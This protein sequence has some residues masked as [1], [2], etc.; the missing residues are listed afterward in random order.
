MADNSREQD[1]SLRSI[2]DM[3]ARSE[4]AQV[5]FTPGTS[6]HTLQRNRIHALR[7]AAALI[8]REAAGGSGAM[9]YT[10]NDQEKARAPLTSLISKSE[11]ARQK[12]APGTWQHN[13]L[14]GNLAALHWAE[15]L[16]SKA[17]ET[18]T[19]E[20]NNGPE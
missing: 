4:N 13:M 12:I 18:G 9:A 1:E 10:K 16:L 8:R 7:V 19:E 17:L 11:K 3:I 6:Q 20:Q 14:I 5:K 15:A 2:A